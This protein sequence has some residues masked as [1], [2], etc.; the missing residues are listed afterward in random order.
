MKTKPLSLL[1]ALV[2]ILGSS[3]PAFGSTSD[4]G[5]IIVDTVLVRPLC[6]VT[7]VFGSAFFVVSLPVAA[8]AGSVE[9]SAQALVVKPV[10]AT[11]TRDLGDFDALMD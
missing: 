3:A 1:L 7:T 5:S 6:F 4:P 9:S 2:L 10:E 8:I 11:F